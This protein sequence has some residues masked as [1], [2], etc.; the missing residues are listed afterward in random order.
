[1]A[2]NTPLPLARKSPVSLLGSIHKQRETGLIIIIAL[3]F[4][5]MSFNSPYFLTWANMKAML[6]SFSIEGSSWWA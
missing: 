5:V 1:M 3:I 6:L 2:L 4:I